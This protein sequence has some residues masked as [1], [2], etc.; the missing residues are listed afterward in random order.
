MSLARFLA[1]SAAAVAVG[2]SLAGAAPALPAAVSASSSLPTI[3]LQQQ[4]PA[5]T[6]AATATFAWASQGA[7]TTTCALDSRPPAFACASPVTLTG[8]GV[9]AH[10]FAVRVAN[11]SG[12]AHAVARWTVTVAPPSPLPS[13]TILSGPAAT[14]SSTTATFAFS[15]TNASTFSCSV[16]SAT[17][18]PC[19]TTVSYTGIVPG[20]HTFVVTAVSGALSASASYA[21]TVDGLAANIWIDPAGSDLG[22]ACT[23]SASGIGEPSPSTVC[24]T[25][26]Q[27]CTLARGGDVVGVAGGT[28]AVG[29]NLTGCNP[30]SP[31]TFE[32]VPGTFVSF[33]P[34]ST[35][36]D[37]SN[38]TL[39]G[40][41]AGYG[42][43]FSLAYTT[44]GGSSRNVVWN[45][46]NLYCQAKAPYV[47]IH[48]NQT[49]ETACNS[50]LNLTGTLNGFTWNGGDQENW[51]V[52][53]TSC[54]HTGIAGN[55]NDD[56]IH[57]GVR[58]VL[59]EHVVFKNYYALDSSGIHS[60][61]WFLDGGDYITFLDDS[62]TDCG[63]PASTGYAVN[64]SCNTAVVFVGQLSGTDVT[65][66]HLSF[67]QDVIA[68]G[69][70]RQKAFQ[71]G[72][73]YPAGIEPT[74]AFEYD[75]LDGS[76][77]VCGVAANPCGP[78]AGSTLTGSN[79][80]F[81]GNVGILSSVGCF[82]SATYSHDIWYS[83]VGYAGRCSP[84][85]E[86]FGFTANATFWASPGVSSF[87]YTPV[88]PAQGAGENSFCPATDING[89]ARPSS[90]S[91]DAGAFQH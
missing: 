55:P 54:T 68:G 73:D 79:M 69:H 65:T 70:P 8:L 74:F 27:A 86:T 75:T 6:S 25:P 89:N 91:C 22:I 84:S 61:E 46:V 51:A 2:G 13:V 24:A 45:D 30:A 67:V 48:S 76:L 21:W 72:Y 60:E 26:Q 85:D 4:P 47:V 12:S 63:P 59:I 62:I 56:F 5:T 82:T 49:N 36:S 7:S 10:T 88:G 1:T 39:Q 44:V 37:S 78:G 35:I 9:G 20:S 42:V 52:C 18:A 77:T 57:P 14:T 66:N 50:A 38:V 64:A 11:A 32:S 53:L 90:T 16:D 80:T 23:R 33:A 83:P 15:A 58:N 31:V 43:G 40:D 29:F 28:Y 19:G 87:D 81:V 34:T 3:A 41:A 71:S 17:A